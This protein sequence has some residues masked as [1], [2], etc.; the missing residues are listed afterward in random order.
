[1]SR[2]YEVAPTLSGSAGPLDKS[3]VGSGISTYF[4]DTDWIINCPGGARR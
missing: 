1:M 3:D 2:V 4:R